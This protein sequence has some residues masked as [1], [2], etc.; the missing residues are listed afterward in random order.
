[1]LLA[2][3]EHL[4]STMANILDKSPEDLSSSELW[5]LVQSRLLLSEIHQQRQVLHVF[6]V[7]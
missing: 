7:E 4:S 5:L 1:M 2:V 6:K 3:A